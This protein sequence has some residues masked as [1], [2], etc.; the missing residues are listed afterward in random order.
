MN[1]HVLF[2]DDDPSFLD[3]L[4]RALYAHHPEWCDEVRLNCKAVLQEMS[5]TAASV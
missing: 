3:E 5:A 4:R 2:V 1:A